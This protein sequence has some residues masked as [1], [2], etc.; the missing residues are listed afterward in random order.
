MGVRLVFQTE[1]SRERWTVRAALTA[2]GFSALSVVFTFMQWKA[3]RR[4]AT[5][6]EASAYDFSALLLPRL[7]SS[8]CT[9]LWHGGPRRN[10]GTG[11][12]WQATLDAACSL[13]KAAAL[14]RTKLRKL[15]I[16]TN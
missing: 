14:R 15:L 10:E 5:A 6:A 1:A 9:L 12:N 16:W 4:S 2:L 7:F 11:L 3:A 8:H 13:A